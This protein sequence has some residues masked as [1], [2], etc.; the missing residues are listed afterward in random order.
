MTELHFPFSAVS[1]QDEFKLALILAAVNPA[2]GGVVISGPRGSAKS[3]LARG[4]ADLLPVT[5]SEQAP[6]FVTL[7]LGT[8]EEML[9]G[10]LDLQ[11]VLDDQNVAFRP[12]LLSKAH[13]GVLYVD[14][15]NLLPDHLVDQLL[16]VVASGVNRV[17]R[18]GISHRHPAR[19]L[20]IGTMNPEE[21]ELRP[22]LHDRFG[23]CVE[24][25]N[26]YSPQERVEIVKSREDFD[27]NP[28]G[29]CGQY[30]DEQGE[31]LD[32]IGNA[33]LCLKDVVCNDD[34][35][36]EIAERCSIAQVD[37]LRADIVWCR[38]ALAHAAW[39]GRNQVTTHDIDAVESLVLAHRRKS[40]VENNPR[41]PAPPSPPQG[42]FKRPEAS[43]R[44]QSKQQNN[45][46]SEREGDWGSMAPQQ[47]RSGALDSFDATATNSP[48]LAAAN[49]V[50]SDLA[51]RTPG[52]AAK[53]NHRSA[54]DSH[55]PH[56][57]TTLVANTGIWPPK[58]LKFQK[59]RAGQSFLHLVLLDTSASTLTQGPE[60]MGK[61]AV[62]KIAEQAYLQREQLS[63]FGFGNGQVENLLPKVRAPKELKNWLDSLP[64]GG[65]TPMRAALEQVQ[66]YLSKATR[67]N[68]ALKI[69]TYIITDGRTSAHLDDV[70]LPGETVL[71]D[72]EQS[73]VKRGRGAQLAVELNAQYL[74]LPAV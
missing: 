9:L 20:L 24:L 37:G 33:R 25:D 48:N 16:D 11:R 31:L 45:S 28:A 43:H 49:Q 8:S 69:R 12:G 62:L 27:R 41:P 34:L 36:L 68:P 39:L 6:E 74:P 30:A 52:Q 54:R 14:E 4:L 63:I 13:G 67:Q 58:A 42:G 59:V 73:A 32:R 70:A 60:S 71:I 47:Q 55:K 22:Q 64:A 21:G 10:T 61:A 29:F 18:D 66:S 19:F 72:I 5:E 56:W 65:G 17:E 53:G 40:P 26:Q 1:G 50:V 35:R 7:P 2:I 46:K 51:G 38:A 15:V 23:L 57:F 44:P 3:T